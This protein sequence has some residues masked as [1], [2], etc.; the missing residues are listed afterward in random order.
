MLL[1]LLLLLLLLAAGLC[2]SAAVSA[3]PLLL[4]LPR[5]CC[6][7]CRFCWRC[8]FCCCC[9]GVAAAAGCSCRGCWR[10]KARRWR[11]CKQRRWPWPRRWRWRRR[12]WPPGGRAALAV[13]VAHHVRRLLQRFFK[14]RGRAVHSDLAMT[15]PLFS[16]AVRHSALSLAFHH[17]LVGEVEHRPV[18]AFWRLQRPKQRH[19]PRLHCVSRGNPSRGNPSRA[20][21]ENREESLRV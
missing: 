18:Q 16:V 6:W 9:R 19:M 14:A 12:L 20:K 7:C 8:R 5:C 3:R 21:S 2:V 1:L 11:P 10:S 13:L 17:A 15:T 4:L